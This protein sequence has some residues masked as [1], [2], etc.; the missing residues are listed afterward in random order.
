METFTE[1]KEPDC[2]FH[3]S[4]A[5]N[6]LNNSSDNSTVTSST[7]MATHVPPVPPAAAKGSKYKKRQYCLFCQ[8]PFYKLA[9]HLGA[10]HRNEREVALAFSLKKGSRKRKEMLSSLRNRGNF[11][12]NS[13]VASSGVGE[14]VVCRRP[15]ESKPPSDFVHCKVCQGL[16]ARKTLWRHIKNTHNPS[17]QGESKG[18][19]K[20]MY[21]FI[22]LPMPAFNPQDKMEEDSGEGVS[23]DQHQIEGSPDETCK[24]EPSE[25]TTQEEMKPNDPNSQSS[26]ALPQNM[27]KSSPGHSIPKQ[28]A[29]RRKAWTLDEVK[30]VERHMMDFITRRKVPG[31]RSC[32]SCLQSEPHALKDR[33]WINIKSFVHNR[34]TASK[35]K[36]KL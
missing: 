25:S 27:S 28:V 2:S 32:T 22:R 23:T 10:V 8:K 13:T 30:A 9:R 36:L 12:H 17:I 24:G 6:S 15:G 14:L 29:R 16:F 35:K 34:I 21:S 3:D 31:K 33:D 11:F 1:T 26:T 18:R 19:R 5:Q 4:R 7:D 20:R